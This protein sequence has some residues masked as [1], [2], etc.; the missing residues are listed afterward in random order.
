MARYVEGLDRRQSFLLPDS[1]QDYVGEDNPVRVI[2]V[3][4]DRIDLSELGFGRAVPADT[5]RPGYHPATL[6]KLYLYGYLNSIP[7]SRRL[8]REAQRNLELMWLTNR[9][10]P[11]FKTIADFRRD[12]GAAIRGTCRQFVMLCR[13]MDLLS[14]V[15][16]AIDGSKFKAVNARDKNFTPAKLQHR[17]EQI[18]ESVAR[19]MAAM[20]TADRQENA[21]ASPKSTR[22]GEK[23]ERLKVQMQRLRDLQIAVKA[24]PDEQISLTDPDSRSMATSGKG[25]GIVGYN[26]QAAVDARHHLIVAHDVTNVGHDR[27]ELARMATQ[28]KD[29]MGH[30]QITAV[31]DRGYFSGWEIYRCEQAGIVPYVPKPLTSGAKFEGR[32][33]KQDFVYLPGKD[34][35]RCPAGEHLKWWYDRHEDGKVLRHYWTTKCRDCAVKADCTTGKERRIK[36]WEHE[37]VLDAMQQRLDQAPQAMAIRRQTVE[38][39]FGTIK[40]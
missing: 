15:M 40:A 2:D 6:L 1:I 35:Y 25:T 32:F 18:E 3:F 7:S 30:D 14:E 23:I 28:A 19:Y 17:I 38:H 22:L 37:A 26:V 27:A 11:D 8:E 31:A 12:H 20:D 36:R 16:V 5:G 13:Q 4:V 34:V 24:A 33:G 21:A 9:L 29:A 10:A 39:I